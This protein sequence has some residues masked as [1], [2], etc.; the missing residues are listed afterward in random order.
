MTADTASTEF[1]LNETT[2]ESYPSS[3]IDPSDVTLSTLL[4]ESLAEHLIINFKTSN[5]TSDSLRKITLEVVSNVSSSLRDI[6]NLTTDQAN[7]SGVINDSNYANDF[8]NDSPASNDTVY[9]PTILEL[10]T[11]MLTSRKDL[12]KEKW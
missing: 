8:G 4:A 9:N 11:S 1:P 6:W 10:N 5:I 3:S 2:S 7:S 12:S